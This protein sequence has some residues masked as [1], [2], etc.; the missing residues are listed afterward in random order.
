MAAARRA[1][2]GHT[3]GFIKRGVEDARAR[4]QEIGDGSGLLGLGKARGIV[5]DTEAADAGLEIDLALL[6]PQSRSRR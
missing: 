3:R 4:F 6:G 2:P 1:Q 5:V